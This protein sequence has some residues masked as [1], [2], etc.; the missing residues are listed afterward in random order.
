MVP[1][2]T[3]N[4]RA[5]P[6]CTIVAKDASDT[7]LAAV[8]APIGAE[9]HRELWRQRDRRGWPTHLLGQ[10]GEWLHA[11]GSE[12]D[13]ADLDEAVR[14]ERHRLQTS[15][16]E[17]ALVERFDVIEI[18]SGPRSPLLA[19]CSRRGLRVGPRIDLNSSPAW[20]FRSWRLIEWL[21]FLI[22]N[23]RVLY[24]HLG[25]PRSTFSLAR[26][27]PLRSRARPMGFDPQE[28]CTR[29]GNEILSLTLAVLTAVRQNSLVAGS[30]AYPRHSLSWLTPPVVKF[31]GHADCGSLWFAT[32]S[33][34][35][36]SR[37]DVRLGYTNA[38]FLTSLARP[39]TGFHRHRLR[40]TAGTSLAEYPDALCDE[41]ASVVCGHVGAARKAAEGDQTDA[42][43]E[44]ETGGPAG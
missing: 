13:R 1:A 3:A 30:W 7:A 43:T 37:H 15:D 44:L 21:M 29:L 17:R 22:E 4:V 20:D 19:A 25:P 42:W 10:H 18:F 2:M 34:G 35:C 31:L 24:I 8:A 33:Y 23:S 11:R 16:P 41:W 12:L 9:L 27:P 14:A 6:R 36:Q 5:H 32:C 39:C 38:H 40:D 26:R 28:P